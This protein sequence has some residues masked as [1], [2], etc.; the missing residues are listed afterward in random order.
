MTCSRLSQSLKTCSCILVGRSLVGIAGLHARALL[1]QACVV[2][3]FQAIVKMEGNKV[4][5]SFPN[6]QHTSEIV[7]DKLVEVSVL[8]VPSWL[9]ALGFPLRT[10]KQVCFRPQQGSPGSRWLGSAL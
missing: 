1:T 6:Y 7:G 2:L 10:V 5:A 9:V 8:L 4:V 3:P